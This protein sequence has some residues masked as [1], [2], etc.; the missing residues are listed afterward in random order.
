MLSFMQLLFESLRISGL[1]SAAVGFIVGSLLFSALD[2]VLPDKHF[3]SEKRVISSKMFRTGSLIAI[4]ISLH[5]LPEGIAFA[6]GY[7]LTP[8]VGLVIATAIAHHNI[9]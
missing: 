3:L 4:G 6:S 9:P 1:F 5:N 2:F 8:E 7:F